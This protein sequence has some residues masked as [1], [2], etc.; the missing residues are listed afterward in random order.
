MRG[1]KSLAPSSVIKKEEMEE[2]KMGWICLKL[3]SDYLELLWS[4]LKNS[5]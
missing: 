3:A 5:P 2:I 1:L 4:C